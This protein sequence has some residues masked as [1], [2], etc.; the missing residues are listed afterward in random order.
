MPDLHRICKRFM[1]GVASLEDVVRVYQV[2]IKVPFSSSSSSMPKLTYTTIQLPGMIDTLSAVE[3]PSSS[4][5]AEDDMDTESPSQDY[6][7]LLKETHLAPITTSHSALAKFGEMVEET[8]DLDALERHQFVI[9]PE[10]DERLG[11]V[12][13]IYRSLAVWS[14]GADQFAYLRS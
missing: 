4:S 13:W 11:E 14:L 12:R 6:L 5:S 10:Y 9:K 2:V 7:E 1:K 8:L 3:A